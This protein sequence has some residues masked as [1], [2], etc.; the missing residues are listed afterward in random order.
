M[1]ELKVIAITKQKDYYRIG[2]SFNYSSWYA[3]KNVLDVTVSQGDLV[4]ITHEKVGKENVLKSI[5]VLGRAETTTTVKPN[6]TD[7]G[8][9]V[10]NSIRKQTIAKAVPE[11]LKAMDLSGLGI[12]DIKPMIEELFEV[13]EKL[14]K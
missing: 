8:T 3:T 11:T 12:E 9:D 6:G 2:E 5:N 4:G 7:K 13:Y 1:S 10:N 14:T